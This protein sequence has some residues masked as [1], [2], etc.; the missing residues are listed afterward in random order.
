MGLPETITLTNRT[1][2]VLRATYDGQEF[3]F[4][5][6]ENHGV[7]TIVVRFAKAQNPL[8]GSDDPYNPSDCQFLVGVK[9]WGD[10]VAPLK[11][12][13]VEERINRSLLEGDGAK[14]VKGPSSKPRRGEVYVNQDTDGVAAAANQ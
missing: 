7:P 12:S 4:K 11:Q 5:P 14:A 13:N 10:P 9:E 2:H 1:P 6:G 8:M 3:V